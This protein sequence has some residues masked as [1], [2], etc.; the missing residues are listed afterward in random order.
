[1]LPTR[2]AHRQ[3]GIALV[4]VLWV[5]SLLTVIALGLTTT[6]RTETAL[7]R[8]QIDSA[9]FRASADAVINLVLLDLLSTPLETDLEVQPW[10]PN[11]VPRELLF[12]GER[13]EVV[14]FNEASRVDLNQATKQQLAALIEV[15]V[16]GTGEDPVMIDAVAD[17]ILDWRDP[18]DLTQ[19]NG[20][21]DG[22]YDAAGLP[23]GAAD[24][25]F[26]SV[27][28][29]RLVLGMTPAL[30]A[31]LADDLTVETGS[32]SV[33]E[34]FASAAVLAAMRG[35]T[36]EDAQLL[37]EERALPVVP[38]A[39]QSRYVDRGGPLYRVRVTLASG[40]RSR[41]SME[42]MVA[43]EPGSVPPFEIKW[44]RYGLMDSTSAAAE[45]DT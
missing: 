18:D 7:A 4:L 27:E 23:Y 19:L 37:V 20:A 11:G 10:E 22:D 42:A 34:Q 1:M 17:A 21:E 29:L 36:L 35:V 14:L 28:E 30:Y 5:L 8:N 26:R 43:L 13:F 6:Q 44:R 12:D 32:S 16:G 9:R 40:E 3:R 15:A 2:S 39:Q 33:A 25:P 24:V 45:P 41:R 38:G 31:R